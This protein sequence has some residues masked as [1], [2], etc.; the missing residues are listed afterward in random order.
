MRYL[1][2]VEL[3]VTSDGPSD[4]KIASEIAPY[5]CNNYLKIFQINFFS[6]VDCQFS[7]RH[8]RCI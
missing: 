6:S 7:K 1:G 8:R 4:I 3:L 5:N 2:V